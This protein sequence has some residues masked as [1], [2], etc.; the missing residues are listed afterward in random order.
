[1]STDQPSTV[2]EQAEARQKGEGLWAYTDVAAYL[3]VGIS[4]VRRYVAQEGLPT[5]RF[6]GVVRFDP[7]AV[8]DWARSRAA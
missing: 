5:V 7:T 2:S 8:R 1:M 4:T 3:K 6:A